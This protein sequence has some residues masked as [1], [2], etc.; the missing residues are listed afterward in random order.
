MCTCGTLLSRIVKL[1]WAGLKTSWE[2]PRRGE[3]LAPLGGRLLGGEPCWIGHVSPA[4]R[5]PTSSRAEELGCK[6]MRG[7][8]VPSKSDGPLWSAP[9]VPERRHRIRLR[10]AAGPSP[11][12]KFS[13]RR[14]ARPAAQ[15]CWKRLASIGSSSLVRSRSGRPLFAGIA[16]TW[17]T[18]QGAGTAWVLPARG[19]DRGCDDDSPS[20]RGR[21]RTGRF[22]SSNAT[23]ARDIQDDLALPPV[24]HDNGVAYGVRINRAKREAG[25]AQWEEKT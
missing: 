25:G 7:R 14:C 16:R 10:P 1:I 2:R 19:G 18:H 24:A 23:G 13:P 11:R 9:G 3:D 22:S 20:L 5:S 8:S 17:R 12:A 4:P 21:S 15:P 6:G